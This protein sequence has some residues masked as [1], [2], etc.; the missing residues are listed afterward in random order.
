MIRQ[1]KQECW[2]YKTGAPASL[3]HGCDYF[4]PIPNEGHDCHN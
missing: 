2:K 3:P 4:T 1:P